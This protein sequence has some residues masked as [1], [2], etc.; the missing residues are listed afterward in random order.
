MIFYKEFISSNDTVFED[1][2]YK[3]HEWSNE[4][5]ERMW[6]TSANNPIIK[7]QFYP[8]RYWMDLLKWSTNKVSYNFKANILDIGCGSGNLIECIN[9]YYK[10]SN[11]YGIDL[12][13]GSLQKVR[14]RF[15][16]NSNIYLKMGTLDN[17]PFC[18]NSL[19]MITCTEVL[20]HT[21][22][23]TFKNSFK[24]VSRVLKPG[25]YYLAT[26]PINEKPAFVCCPECQSIF[27]PYQHM[28]FDITYKDIENS[29]HNNNMEIVEYYKSVNRTS[30]KN[31][32]KRVIKNI[33][34]KF[35]PIIASRLFA[36]SGVT[37]FLAKKK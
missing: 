8:I 13:E 2:K 37:G 15:K 36:K 23:E 9:K 14:E 27:T 30:P 34:I 25:G 24:E 12:T 29:L 32:L 3:Y 31:I 17:I 20:E 21:F 26:V 16:Y 19:D 22:P 6:D 7:E 1:S 33:I 18:D 28:N 4:S 10:N 5:I 35:F 11:I